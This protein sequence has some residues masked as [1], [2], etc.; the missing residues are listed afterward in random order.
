V[1]PIETHLARYQLAGLFLDTLPYNAHA[2]AC[3]ALWA[4]LPVLTCRGRS[5]AGRVGASLLEALGLPE[6][7][8]NTLQGYEQRALQL[9]RDATLLASI[10]AKL[11]LARGTSPVFDTILYCRNLEAAYTSMWTRLCAA[12]LPP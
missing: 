9:A 8:A 1:Q 12:H 6:L 3:D 5:F 10:R 11:A 2:T 4:G 7:I